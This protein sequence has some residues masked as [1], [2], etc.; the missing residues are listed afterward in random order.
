MTGYTPVPAVAAGDWIDEIFINTYWADNMAAGLPDLFSAKGQLA[1]GLGVDDMGILNVGS[2]NQ[3]LVA[4][5][6]QT[7][8]VDWKDVADLINFAAIAARVGGS[9]T[10]WA[11]A[12]SSNYTPTTSFAQIGSGN[13]SFI[14]TP[15]A[16]SAT[17]TFPI[18]FVYAPIVFV[19]K[20]FESVGVADF[21]PTNVTN[22]NFVINVKYDGARSGS[23]SYRWLAIGE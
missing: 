20:D 7:L 4:D 16:G 12:G 3:V 2:D 8:G 23:V 15:G 9:A 1:V 22:T 10:V 21:G 5:S 14:G 11:T 13:V 17:V 19:T 18:A 6:A